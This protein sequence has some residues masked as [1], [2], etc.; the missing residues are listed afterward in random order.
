[1]RTLLAIAPGLA[2]LLA[3][4][5]CD[6]GADAYKE[7]PVL[8]VTSPSRS[9]MR[10]DSGQVTVTGTVAPNA[11]GDAIQKVLVNNVEATVDPTGH[12]TA[13]ISVPEGATLIHTSARDANDGEATDTRAVHAGQ[14]LTAGSNV[15]RGLAA[16]LSTEAF[17]KISAA[18][19]PIIKG[20][21]IGQ[22]IAPMNPMIHSGDENGEDCLFGRVYIDDVKFEDIAISLVPQQGGLGFRAQIDKLDVP[23]RARY[24]VACVDGSNTVRVKATRVVITGTLLVTPAGRGSFTTDLVDENVQ[25][26]G[27]DIQASGLPGAILDILNLENSIRGV[28]A[29]GVEK[30]ME[31]MMN[32][33]LGALGG[34][35]ELEVLGKKIQMQVDPSD[36]TFDPAG[37]LIVM[38]T[39]VLIAGSE[40]SRFVY[41]ENG[42]PSLDPGRGFALGLADDLANELLSEANAVGLLNLAMPAT[43]GTFDNTNVGMTLPPMI[44][45]DPADGTMKV[46]L[47][48]MTATFTSLGKPVGKAAINATVDLKIEPAANGYGVALKLGKPVIHADVLDD[49]PNET[50]M[51]DRD[52]ASAVEVC[53]DAQIESI[54]KLLVSIP[55][56]AVA[57]LQMRNLSV[58]S[59]DGYVM[60]KGSLE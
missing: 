5:A 11:S 44:S 18:A 54:S 55:L 56:P 46:V 60:V 40:N 15:E 24:A 35:Q 50:R 25:I 20:L 47:G 23:G 8:K 13:T 53:L 21:D 30:A 32:S 9:H 3:A 7:P 27:L 58:G 10:P 51:M 34:P 1:M 45:A 29:R 17:A 16:A 14:Q 48:D 52:L 59:D 42:F 31:P 36:V 2:S 37:G 41:T 57:G 12:F 38:D 26:T 28:I 49:M 4:A 6:G 33:A 43:G 22:M 19:G 39:K